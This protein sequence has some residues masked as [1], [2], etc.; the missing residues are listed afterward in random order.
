M[1]LDLNISEPGQER[2]KDKDTPREVTE[3]MH[4]RQ[5]FGAWEALERVAS[6]QAL[7]TPQALFDL[8][9]D[10]LSGL[11]GVALPRPDGA[12]YLYPDVSGLFG[13]S[14]PSGRLIES[15]EEL[16]Y[17]LLEEHDLALVPGEGFGDPRGIRLSYAASDA[18]LNE[19]AD[20]F[21]AAVN[22]LS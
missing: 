18:V 12:F 20:R 11:D 3:Y 13:R 6:C 1:D 22:A 7:E 8:L 2:D 5:F 15:A 16:A 10:R 19:A 21:I 9:I 14:A 4:Y 17:Y